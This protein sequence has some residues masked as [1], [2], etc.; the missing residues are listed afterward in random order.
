MAEI[1]ID[2]DEALYNAVVESMTHKSRG[3][4]QYC[5]ECGKRVGYVVRLKDYNDF[6]IICKGCYAK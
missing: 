3:E 6:V 4:K 2:L 5:H 1:E